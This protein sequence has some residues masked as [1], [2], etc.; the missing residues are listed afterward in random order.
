[1]HE[2]PFL[3]TD[4]H[5]T[6]QTSTNAP[7]TK[8]CR[9]VQNGCGSTVGI[10]TPASLTLNPS[11]DPQAKTCQHNGP[12]HHNKTTRTKPQRNTPSFSPTAD[13]MAIHINNDENNVPTKTVIR[14]NGQTKPQ[15]TVPPISNGTIKLR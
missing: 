11:F 1:M 5:P 9:T 14:K 12:P 6:Q 13:S 10:S 15:L 2:K 8:S 4:R 3:G 7:Q